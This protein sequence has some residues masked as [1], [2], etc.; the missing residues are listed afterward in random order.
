MEE[1]TLHDMLAQS[2]SKLTHMYEGGSPPPRVTFLDLPQNVRDQIYHEGG[3]WGNRFI[4][5][6]V[7]S[8]KDKSYKK[9]P[10]PAALLWAGSHL[11]HD[12][13]ETKLYAENILAVSMLGERGLQ[14]LEMMSDT[15][16][17]EL[18]T[19]IISFLPCRYRSQ[20]DFF[21]YHTGWFDGER[22]DNLPSF[23]KHVTHRLC[24][25]FVHIDTSI[26]AQWKR[27]CARLAANSRPHQLSL[28]LIASVG[29]V[30]TA[31]SILEPL[32][33]M[34]PLRDVAIN[35]GDH[36][37]D[38]KDFDS[39]SFI[40]NAAKGLL[41]ESIEKPP[42]RFMSLPLELQ[43]QILQHTPLLAGE[44]VHFRRSKAF[45]LG[46]SKKTCSNYRLKARDGK[47]RFS[48][49]M[50]SSTSFCVRL[51][52]DAFTQHCECDSFRLDKY[53]KV[54]KEFSY[55]ARHVFYSSNKLCFHPAFLRDNELRHALPRFMRR[56]PL[57]SLWSL[58]RLCVIFPA[59][60]PDYIL[61]D[62]FDWHEWVESIQRLSDQADLSRLRLEVHF[63]GYPSP[64]PDG[65]LF[66]FSLHGQY[67]YELMWPY[68]SRL[69]RRD[70]S[71]E[72]TMFNTYKRML[73]P[74]KKL[75]CKLLSMQVYFPWAPVESVL[76]QRK[77]YEQALE[78]MIMGDK[79]D[80][81]K[82]GK[83]DTSEFFKIKKL[84]I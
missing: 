23:W 10:F 67:M 77:E 14:P 40:R 45:R 33:G 66:D 46:D 18:R 1:T 5:L 75:G 63:S 61:P 37:K 58:R 65:A 57:E 15:A 9:P 4:D 48:Q 78:Q 22:E 74:L 35:L 62:Q 69:V 39:R 55:I 83:R 24:F 21:K 12:E 2:T 30:E 70:E 13:V 44:N 73:E 56:V 41:G 43:I 81:A 6:N 50:A 26:L 76:K 42:F 80:S 64:S 36:L 3:Y 54:S 72:K 27:I 28:S 59:C 8:Y 49:P 31:K 84:E 19:L 20:D 25:G 71:M 16:L 34:P 11:I 51:Y 79:Y 7:W 52:P 32:S 47:D 38:M 60:S 68:T 82:W 17:R 29:D 53:F